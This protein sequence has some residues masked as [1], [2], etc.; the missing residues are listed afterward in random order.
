M[1][2]ERPAITDQMVIA[3]IRK[4]IDRKGC[5]Q[6]AIAIDTGVSECVLSNILNQ[7]RRIRLSE[8]FAVC[9][10]LDVDPT[11]P[12]V[13]AYGRTGAPQNNEKRGG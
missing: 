10:A 5:Q 11:V 12:L 13:M 8:Y 4:I 1:K 6:K 3:A 7:K 9:Q 2:A